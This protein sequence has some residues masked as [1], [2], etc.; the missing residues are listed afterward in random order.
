VVPDRYEEWTLVLREE[1]RNAYIRVAGALADDAT[2]AGEDAR[3]AAYLLRVLERDPYD[4]Q[5][6]LALIRAFAAGRR[7]GEARRAYRGYA[8]RLAEIGLEPQPFPVAI[9]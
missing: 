8:M 9:T 3:A 4:E 5:A 7:H 6:H 1:A 2:S